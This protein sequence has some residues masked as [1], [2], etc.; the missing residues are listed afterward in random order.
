[1]RKAC[2]LPAGEGL[3]KGYAL[4][5][6]GG[7]A[8]LKRLRCEQRGQR[9]SAPQTAK[10][11]ALVCI[12]D[13]DTETQAIASWLSSRDSQESPRLGRYRSRF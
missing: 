4:V 1:M 10:P 8:R 12:I 3:T 7:V 2:G 11:Q 5:Q 6:H 9:P 13:I